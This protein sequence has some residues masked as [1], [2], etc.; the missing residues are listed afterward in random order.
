MHQSACCGFE[1]WPGLRPAPGIGTIVGRIACKTQV[2]PAHPSGPGGGADEGH[3]DRSDSGTVV[4]VDR[5]D[6]LPGSQFEAAV[7]DRQVDGRPDQCGLDVAVSVPVVPC[8]L[9]RIF[10]AWRGHPVINNVPS[11]S[12]FS[13]KRRSPLHFTALLR[14][15][16][17]ANILILKPNNITPNTFFT[18]AT[19]NLWDSLAPSGAAK[20]LVIEI[21]N[22]AGR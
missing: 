18:T 3:F 17:E 16:T 6:L 2:S 9:V 7:S 11:F 21:N 15:S 22:A 1:Q 5:H 10:D 14:Y 4:V 20:K 19:G 12:S 8:Q 13:C